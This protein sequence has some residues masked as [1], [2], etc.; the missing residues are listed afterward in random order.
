MNIFELIIG[1]APVQNTEKPKRVRMPTIPPEE[2]RY[3]NFDRGCPNCQVRARHVT[4]G[5]ITRPY[6]LQCDREKRR[7]YYYESR[8][9]GFVQ[10][11]ARRKPGLCLCGKS[12]KHIAKSGVVQSYCRE[13]MAVVRNRSRRKQNELT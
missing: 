6:C 8:K 1:K 4:K 10:Q 2:R 12:D 9:R 11:P 5:G 3:A 13:C 7:Q